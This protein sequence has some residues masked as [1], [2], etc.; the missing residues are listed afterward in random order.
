[1]AAYCFFCVNVVATIVLLPTTRSPPSSSSFPPFFSFFIHL[2]CL[3]RGVAGGSVVDPGAVLGE[4]F[5]FFPPIFWQL[6]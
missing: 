1:M 5:F 2:P 3:S 6:K 4:G